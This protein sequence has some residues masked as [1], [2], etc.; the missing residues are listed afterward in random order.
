MIYTL[1]LRYQKSRIRNSSSWLRSESGM[2]SRGE[3]R[4]HSIFREVRPA[5]ALQLFKLGH[6][7]SRFLSEGSLRGSRQMEF[8]V[9]DSTCNS[10]SIMCEFTNLWS[11][12]S[13]NGSQTCKTVSEG[14]WLTVA[15]LGQFRSFSDWSDGKAGNSLRFAHFEINS[16]CRVVEAGSV[17]TFLQ[18]YKVKLRKETKGTGGR[19]INSKA[20]PIN[21]VSK[22]EKSPSCTPDHSEN[23]YMSSK[24]KLDNEWN[25]FTL[26]SRVQNSRPMRSTFS[27][28][29]I[30]RYLRE[31]SSPSDIG[32]ALIVLAWKMMYCPTNWDISCS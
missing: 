28:W 11:I 20:L 25:A 31:G 23:R 19:D 4:I 26:G 5:K 12:S 16:S 10:S 7:T 22:Q 9:S 30:S 18:L 1:I 24:N 32:V 29:R 8:I 6:L 17:T 13:L 14:N 15:R 21:M 27:I 2:W 3:Q